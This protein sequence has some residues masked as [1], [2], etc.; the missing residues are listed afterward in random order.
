MLEKNAYIY[1]KYI[2]NYDENTIDED[3]P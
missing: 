1:M 3:K 2:V